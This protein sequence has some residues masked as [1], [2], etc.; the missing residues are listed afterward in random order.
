MEIA[1]HFNFFGT[2]PFDWIDINIF[3]Q[4]QYTPGKR[5]YG[6]FSRTSNHAAP[7]C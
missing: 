3:Y 7:Y 4:I 2:Y 5:T 6:T 1:G